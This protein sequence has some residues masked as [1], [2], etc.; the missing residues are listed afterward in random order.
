M[1]RLAIRVT[2]L[3]TLISTRL[4]S[5]ASTPRPDAGKTPTPRA[6]QPNRGADAIKQGQVSQTA[7][8]QRLR[9]AE[10]LFNRGENDLACDQVQQAIRLAPNSANSQ[11]QRFCSACAAP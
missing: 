7:V 2:L 10:D 9:E 4:G 5:C 3:S 8:Q 6:D 11:L 1:R